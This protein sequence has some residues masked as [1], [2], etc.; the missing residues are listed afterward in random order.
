[1]EMIV[2]MTLGKFKNIVCYLN[3]ENHRRSDMLLGNCLNMFLS[4]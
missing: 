4:P 2:A 1:M 3:R